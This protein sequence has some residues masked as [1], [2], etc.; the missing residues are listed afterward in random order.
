MVCIIIYNYNSKEENKIKFSQLLQAASSMTKVHVTPPID[1]ILAGFRQDVLELANINSCLEKLYAQY[2]GQSKLHSKV[3]N[4][5]KEKSIKNLTN[6]EFIPFCFPLIG[7]TCEQIDADIKTH[8]KPSQR[9]FLYREKR[10][11]LLQKLQFL[12]K[13]SALSSPSISIPQVRY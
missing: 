8:A 9:F 6:P 13:E 3:E 4:F 12:P 10:L 11:T 5:L 1:R 2:K 7:T